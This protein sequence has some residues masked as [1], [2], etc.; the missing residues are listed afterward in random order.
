MRHANPRQLKAHL[1]HKV[2]QRQ[3]EGLEVDKKCAKILKEKYGVT[4]V[5][6][7]GSLLN[8]EKMS[9]HS[10][11]DFAVSDLPEK[12]YFKALAELDRGHDFEIDL[13]EIEK[14]HS[15]ILDAIYQGVEL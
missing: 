13:V 1:P 8:H 9:P 10:D 3:K 7:F 12:D 6:L 2:K 5:I 11:L 15:Y 4:K 14:A